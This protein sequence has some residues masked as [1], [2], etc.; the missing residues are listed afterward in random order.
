MHYQFARER[1]NYSDLAS[2]RVFCSRPGHPAFPVRLASEIFQR[3]MAIRYAK[4]SSTRCVLYDPC[5]GAA[6]HLCVLAYLHRECIQEVIGSDIEEG[7]IALAKRNLD[8]LN[9]SGLDKRIDEITE[10]LRLYE[11]ES[12]KEALGSAKVLRK[13]VA[14]LEQT[15]PLKTSTFQANATDS[16]NLQENL[17]GVKV[18]IV[19]ADIPYGLHSQWLSPGPKI[20]PSNSLGLMLDALLGVLLPTSIV[21]VVT[22]KQQRINH[23]NYLTLER[24]QVG[25]RRVKIMQ[26]FPA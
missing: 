19:F 20:P 21:A 6:Y 24:F 1:L 22:D 11:K 9:L 23:Q 15:H 13:K 8:M 10:M 25:K 14:A 7:A 4:N 18:D 16:K 5:C 2:G 26:P 17:K 3:C 12:H